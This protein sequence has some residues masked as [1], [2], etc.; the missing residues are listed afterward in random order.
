VLF[1][2][3]VV[4]SAVFAIWA[5]GRMAALDVAC[6]VEGAAEKARIA[7]ERQPVLRGEG[8]DENAAPLYRKAFFGLETLDAATVDAHCSGLKPGQALSAEAAGFVDEHRAQIAAVRDATHCTR[9]DWEFE[10]EKG[11]AAPLPPLLSV[12]FLAQLTIAEGYER[13]AAGDAAGAAERFADV[14]RFGSDFH[15]GPLIMQMIS[16][17]V[18]EKAI[19]AIA[20]AIAFGSFPAPVRAQ[21]AAEV[22]KL[23]TSGSRA[24]LA[25]SMRVERL[26]LERLILSGVGDNLTGVDADAAAFEGL[27][28]FGNRSFA[29]L[30]PDMDAFLRD[31]EEACQITDRAEWDK[32]AAAILSR[33]EA[34]RNPFVRVATPNAAAAVAFQD[35]LMARIRLCQ[36]ALAL[37]DERGAGGTFPAEPELLVDPCAS[38]AKLHYKLAEDRKGYKLWSVGENGKDDGGIFNRRP[39]EGQPGF[40]D[41]LVLERKE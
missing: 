37:E 31:V 13:L 29:L 27:R 17:V 21:L 16:I 15:A 23:E 36:T 30:L 22:A 38:P 20:D 8:R 11:V 4:A 28:I 9:C 32:Q 25:D 35:R 14:L 33:V 3:L 26:Q 2:L 12:R 7:A 18:E 1:A 5:N 6:A 40:G 39:G 24:R 34:S 19:G 10:W 41:D